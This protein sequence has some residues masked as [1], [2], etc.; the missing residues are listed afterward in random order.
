M[1]DPAGVSTA[2]DRLYTH[3][4]S[5]NSFLCFFLSDSVIRAEIRNKALTLSPRDQ[6]PGEMAPFIPDESWLKKR[7]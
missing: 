2:I 1:T 3:R 4:I 7:Y 6:T 5:R